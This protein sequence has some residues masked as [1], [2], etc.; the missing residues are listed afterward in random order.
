MGS[1][2]ARCS[3]SALAMP[4]FPSAFSKSMGFTL[5]GM[6]EEPTSLGFV[7]CLK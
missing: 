4:R 7:F 5:C 1:L 2:A 6:A 3:R